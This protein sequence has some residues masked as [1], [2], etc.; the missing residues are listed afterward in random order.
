ML[1]ISQAGNVPHEMQCSSM[2]LFAK[3]VLGEFKD[4]DMSG[5][6]AKAERAAMINEKALARKPKQEQKALDYTI[7]AAGHHSE[8]GAQVT[9]S[10][11]KQ[12]LRHAE[13]AV[14]RAQGEASNLASF[15]NGLGC[16]SVSE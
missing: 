16:R 8:M 3:E 6:H 7:P 12:T 14:C 11:L 15:R 10:G 13:S 9:T 4:R 1:C 2:E 5:A